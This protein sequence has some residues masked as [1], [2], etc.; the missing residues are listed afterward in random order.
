MDKI[1]IAVPCMDSVATG[2]ASSLISLELRQQVGNCGHA[3][4]TSS[5]IYDSRNCLAIEALKAEADYVLWLDSDMAFEGDILDRLMKT[6]HEYDADMVSGLYFRRVPPY[7]P[8]VFPRFI[9]NEGRGL[10]SWVDF[11]GELKGVQE[12]DAVGF[13]CVLMKTEVLKKVHEKY[14]DFFSPIGKVGEDLSFCWRA[15][16]CNCKLMV[17]CDVRLGHLGTIMITDEF[18]FKYLEDHKKEGE[19]NGNAHLPKV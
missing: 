1:L 12:V 7:S 17:D 10:A 13:G 5:L 9:V 14:D 11:D 6:L 15:K 2:F 16:Q 4:Y 3:F 18:Y 8:V 19:D